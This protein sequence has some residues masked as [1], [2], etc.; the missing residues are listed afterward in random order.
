MELEPTGAALGAQITGVDPTRP[1][2][3]SDRERLREGLARHGVLFA[4]GQDL[5]PAQVVQFARNGS[6]ITMKWSRS[7]ACTSSAP[8][9]TSRAASTISCAAVPDA[10]AIPGRH[11]STCHSKTT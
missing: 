3:E 5:D 9:G 7:A 6:A 4:R 10:R 11:A 2:S 1:L 8:S